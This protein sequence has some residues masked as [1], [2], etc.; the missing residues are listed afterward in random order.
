MEDIIISIIV[1]AYN[2]EAYIGRCL[3]SIIKQTHTNLE[4]IVVDDGSTDKTGRIIDK[5]ATSDK[6][7]IP[8]HKKNGGVSSARFAGIGIATGLYIGFVDGDDYVEPKM[9]EYL[10]SNIVQY[11]ADISHCGYKMIF[12][13]GHIDYY[14]N[15]KKILFQ[16]NM[17]GLKDLVSG[18]FVEPGLCNKLFSKQL[19]ENLLKHE[20]LFTS[21]RINEDLLLNYFLFKEAKCSVYEDICPYNYILR[22]NSAATS[23]INEN[24]LKD[25]IKV[26]KIIC[27][28]SIDSSEVNKVAEERLFNQMVGIAVMSDRDQPELIRPYRA[29]IRKELKGKLKYIMECEYLSKSTKIKVVWTVLWPASYRLVHT[30]YE[31]VTGLDKKYSIE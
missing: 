14:Y 29:R 31:K 21:I 12:P 6:R 26:M 8:I 2:I 7:I 10:L 22:Q 15:T 5:Y 17:M 18:L 13:D 11:H 16:N 9:F 25:P 3:E 24:K 27:T 1:P 4:I 30:L 23:K 28:N 19:F 20:Q